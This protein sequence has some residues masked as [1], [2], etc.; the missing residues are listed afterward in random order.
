M[1]YVL[2]DA[3]SGECTKNWEGV[4][5]ISARSAALIGVSFTAG[6]VLGGG[7]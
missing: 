1:K 2:L 5:P 6:P 3:E 7:G 4:I